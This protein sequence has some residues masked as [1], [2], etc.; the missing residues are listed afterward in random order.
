M[1]SFKIVMRVWNAGRAA[2]IARLAQF[3]WSLALAVL[4]LSSTPCWG[5]RTANVHAALNPPTQLQNKAGAVV[6]S[7]F[8]NKS[9]LL[10]IYAG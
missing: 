1:P 10:P 2:L 5:K 9:I 6:D 8:K 3:Q 4:L 7:R